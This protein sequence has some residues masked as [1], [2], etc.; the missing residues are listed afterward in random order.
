MARPKVHDEALRG[1]LLERARAV[2]SADGPAALSLRTLARDCE[3]STTAVYSLFGGKPGLLTALFDDAF[4]S[5]GAQPSV[6]A[7]VL[8]GRGKHFT[9][10]LDL[11]HAAEQFAP[12]SDAGRWAEKQLRHIH[13]LQASFDAVEDA[14]PPVVAAAAAAVCVPAKRV[15]MPAS[16]PS[17]SR[18]P[19]RSAAGCC[20][21]SSGGKLKSKSLSV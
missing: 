8:S 2:L 16:V 11:A 20:A 21:I 17:S 15:P 12:S 18:D 14:R 6:R 9:A 5:L 10:G 3:T 1:R 7:V 4:R 19:L 13:W